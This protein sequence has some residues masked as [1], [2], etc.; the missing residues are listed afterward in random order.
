MSNL[1][2]SLKSE[3]F[4]LLSNYPETK[5]FIN[6]L[7]E[8]GELLF[9]GGSV[10]D[11]YVYNSYNNMPRDFDIA[12]KLE[13]RQELIF[14][15]FVEEYSYTKNRFGGYKVVIENIE[16]DLWNFKNTWAFKEN[17][18]S[19]EEE[20]LVKSVY[21]S[22]DG[23]AYNFNKDK[24]YDEELRTTFSNKQIDIVLK[25]NP[26]KDLNLLRALIFRKRYELDFSVELKQEYLRSIELNEN[27]VEK[28]YQLQFSHYHNE[29]LTR[30]EVRVE[31]ENICF[32]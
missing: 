30:N 26:Q 1:K 15:R 28:L 4:D 27:Y 3:I 2:T 9:F 8:I 10:R 12:I 32:C 13:S 17:K 19:T 29:R 6:H 25:D 5:E 7:S 14:E 18:L 22:I 24:L 23:I 21:L 20:N 11:Y 16:F 31:I